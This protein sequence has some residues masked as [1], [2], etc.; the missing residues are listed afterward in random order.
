MKVPDSTYR[1]F[2]LCFY[3]DIYRYLGLVAHLSS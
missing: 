3:L 1:T 2:N